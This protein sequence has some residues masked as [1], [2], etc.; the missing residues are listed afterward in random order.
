MGAAFSFTE[1]FVANERRKN[2][3]LNGAAGG[4]AAG[5]LAGI[6]C[7]SLLLDVYIYL[8]TLKSRCSTLSSNGS[9][10][11]RF[12]G[13]HNGCFRLL[14]STNWRTWGDKRRKTFEVL[15]KTTTTTYRPCI[16]VKYPFSKVSP[17]RMFNFSPTRQR[18]QAL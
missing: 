1:A 4:C 10:R 7:R 16:T 5:F 2:D 11:M 8:W 14:W 17:N 3:A 18:F 6:R 13:C 9:R 15:Q 12:I